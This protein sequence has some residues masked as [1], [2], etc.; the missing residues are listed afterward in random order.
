VRGYRLRQRD[1]DATHAASRGPTPIGDAPFDLA[2]VAAH[3]PAHAGQRA[4]RNAALAEI[5]RTLKPT[6]DGADA[7]FLLGDL[8]YRLS[9]PPPP[10]WH[11]HH[12]AQ[13]QHP[14]FARG[15]AGRGGDHHRDGAAASSAA[16]SNGGDASAHSQRE[17]QKRDFETVARFVKA[18]RLD[19]LYAFDELRDE[20]VGLYPFE[21]L[22]GYA[23]PAPAFEP[24]FKLK[25]KT[26][27]YVYDEKRC[28]A[29]CDRV[30]FKLKNDTVK[31]FDVLAYD[32]CADVTT[33]D[34]KP[35]SLKARLVLHPRFDSTTKA[36]HR[37]GL[38]GGAMITDSPRAQAVHRLAREAA[39][40][41]DARASSPPPPRRE[42]H[43][44]LIASTIAPWHDSHHAARAATPI[45][46]KKPPPDGA[47][48]KPSHRSRSSPPAPPLE[49]PQTPLLHYYS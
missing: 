36:V 22:R 9:L 18:G 45:A 24:T 37:G 11:P 14:H 12:P 34:H 46:S 23:T 17:K 38:R 32:A 6:I 1:D 25:R 7:T 19:A 16:A 2:F 47:A 15:T 13:Q 8:N 43:P 3:L 27:G 40:S 41:N 29:W 39:A 33:S 44:Q 26:L 48:A 49:S 20:L 21:P 5:F 30:L 4:A 31:C 28:P 35:V 42:I 10:D